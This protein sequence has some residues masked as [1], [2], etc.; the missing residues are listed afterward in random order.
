VFGFVGIT[1]LT[2]VRAEGT[3][4]GPDAVKQ[5]LIAAEKQIERLFV[6]S[7]AA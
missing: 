4:M 1:D 2:V 3:N 6:P 5:A 7:R